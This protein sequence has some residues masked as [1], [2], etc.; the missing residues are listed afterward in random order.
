MDR[1][2]AIATALKTLESIEND[3]PHPA[4]VVVLP[5]DAGFIS[6]NSGGFVQL[7]ISSLKAALGTAQPFE[8]LPWVCAYEFDWILKGLTLDESAH[9]YLPPKMTKRSWIADKVLLA[10]ASLLCIFLVACLSVG[11]IDIFHS[12]FKR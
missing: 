3:S 12:I 6:G 9:I 5:P 4:A 2:N 8:G 11:V 7:A 1:Q 10:G